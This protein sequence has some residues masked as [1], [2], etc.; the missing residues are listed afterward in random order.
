MR[1]G[2]SFINSFVAAPAQ[3]ERLFELS[4]DPR[5]RAAHAVKLDV[6]PAPDAVLMPTHYK[7]ARSV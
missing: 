7:T 1:S 3:A 2:R 4:H 6:A 5:E